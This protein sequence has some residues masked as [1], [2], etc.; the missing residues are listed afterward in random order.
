[1]DGFCIR[2]GAMRCQSGADI[3]LKKD[4]P[5][6]DIEAMIA[7]TTNGESGAKYTKPVFVI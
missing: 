2:I 3:Q 1:V 5:V 4:V 6:A 7:P